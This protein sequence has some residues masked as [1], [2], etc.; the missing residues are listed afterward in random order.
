MQQNEHVNENEHANEIELDNETENG[1]GSEH[2]IESN[3][4]ALER[5]LD[6]NIVV[7]LKSGYIN[8]YIYTYICIL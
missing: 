5:V 6:E 1:I 8:I 3:M 7:Y 4:F 2:D